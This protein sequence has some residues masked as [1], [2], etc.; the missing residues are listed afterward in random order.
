MENSVFKVGRG[1]MVSIAVL[2]D[3][4]KKI[5]KITPV[6]MVDGNAKMVKSVFKVGRGVAACQAV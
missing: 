6:L 1:V 4:M 2:M 3:Q 5:V